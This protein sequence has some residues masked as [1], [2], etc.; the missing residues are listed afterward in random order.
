MASNFET[1]KDYTLNQFFSGNNHIVVPDLQ[2]DYCW[3][4]V[5]NDKK[6]L[7]DSFFDS[8][9][10]LFNS[11]KE[12]EIFNLGLIYA[13]EY[14]E[15]YI[16][17]CDGQQRL[18]TIYLLLGLLNKLTS[19]K[20]EQYLVINNTN[21]IKEPFLQYSIR[22]SSL[23][24]LSD[25]VNNFFLNDKVGKAS[26]IKSQSWYFREYDYDPTVVSFLSALNILE[27]KLSAAEIDYED[28]GSFITNYLSFLYYD[29]VNRNNGEETFVVINT[30]GEALSSTENLKPLFISNQRKELQK[31]CSD[32]WE[33]WE[34]YFWKNRNDNDTADN[35]LK[36]FF[37]WIVLLSIDLESK[38]FIEIEESGKYSFDVTKY[39]FDE[40]KGYFNI[41]KYLFDKKFYE[42][43]ILAPNEDGN[44]LIDWFI[45]LP[46]IKFI[47]R[48]GLDDERAILR[49]YKFFTHLS[50]INN[51]SKAVKDLLPKAI[52]IIN[53]M[54]SKDICS[55]LDLD[56]VSDTLLSPE[57][58]T[59][60]NLYKTANNRIDL[61]NYFWKVEETDL[62]NSEINVILKWAT[63]ND[64][65]DFGQFKKYDFAITNIFAATSPSHDILRRIFIKE[66][67]EN[68]PIAK[69]SNYSFC[70]G[71]SDWHKVICE[72]EKKLH[73]FF[74]KYLDCTLEQ[75]KDKLENEL[76]IEI[77]NIENGQTSKKYK[78]YL[79]KILIYPKV[80]EYAKNKNVRWNDDLE[81]WNIIPQQKATSIY[82]LENIIVENKLKSKLTQEGWVTWQH[83]VPTET[84]LVVEKKQ[85]AAI[86]IHYLG[87]KKFDIQLFNRDDNSETAR[88]KVKVVASECG[89]RK[90][91]NSDRY[92]LNDLTDSPKESKL[93]KQILTII[94][95]FEE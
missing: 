62:W 94:D 4:I 30:T 54:P 71:W 93:I 32:E 49:I 20:F 74:K 57:E 8:L 41:I 68:Y 2:R 47:K 45:L 81:T 48:F 46:V 1:G 35:G 82:I 37:R 67:E 56:N 65:F 55:I 15:F 3:G 18:T 60:L 78:D 12:N 80:L 85:V 77:K 63:L 23:Y 87:N 22:E 89:I 16:Q 39:S 24:F 31:S 88:N 21:E 70:Y 44:N 75:I 14:P 40:V 27:K 92:I 26:E 69:G 19:G 58:K 73:S 83:G 28:F 66:L 42:L 53:K 51:V 5:E 64:N 25:L 38:E 50:K 90:G 11:K 29:T 17:L 72:N 13:Y 76:N 61:E 34:H 10:N 84:C 7:V 59:K 52:E 6:N 95:R 33:S 86:D 43:S 36:E 91:Y 9:L 79:D